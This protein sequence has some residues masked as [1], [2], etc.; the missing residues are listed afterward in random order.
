[1]RAVFNLL[2]S[3]FLCVGV[4]IGAGFI[5]GAELVSFFGSK[6]FV[7]YIIIATILLFLSLVS[8]FLLSNRF[9]HLEK[10]NQKILGKRGRLFYFATLISCFILV[11]SMLSALDQIWKGFGV[12]ENFPVL[13][14]S[15]LILVNF[16]IS[17]GIGFLEK[18]S[19]ILVPII[20][21]ICNEICFKKNAFYF[22]SEKIAVLDFS[23]ASVK[24]VFYVSMNVFMS[25]PVLVAT[26]KNKGKKHNIICA[27]LVALIL[28]A[29]SIIILSTICFE[30]QNALNSA[31]PF[32]VAIK[33]QTGNG[34]FITCLLFAIIT[35]LYSSYYPLY[36]HCVQA[37]KKH[38]IVIV[39]V[40]SFIFSRLGLKAIV[41]YLY[42]VIS[43]FGAIYLIRCF[44]YIVVS[45]YKNKKVA[46]NNF[47]KV[48]RKL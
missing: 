15:A 16:T 22:P 41:D 42:P 19:L 48:R 29:Q 45:W 14:I 12:L 32:L 6:N 46:K 5:T 37:N 3:V 26:S 9:G 36:N 8:V 33:G 13:S 43:I 35:S 10:I 27:V 11:S 38:K 1:M 24:A 40:L 18:L 17:K 7:Y 30:G 44:Y 20:L 23:K 25:L 47:S 39:S 2:S 34:I 4:V 31:M 21:V 28:G